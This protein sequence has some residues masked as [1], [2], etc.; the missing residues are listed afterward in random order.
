MCRCPQLN[1][2]VDKPTIHGMLIWTHLKTP[3]LKRMDVPIRYYVR[4]HKHIP[5]LTKVLVPKATMS[6]VGNPRNH[7]LA[8][9]LMV[10]PCLHVTL[11]TMLPTQWNIATRRLPA[12]KLFKL[13][14][15]QMPVWKPFLKLDLQAKPKSSSY[16]SFYTMN[17]IATRR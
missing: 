9:S 13:L 8:S 4:V 12:H 5:T 6:T 14:Q 7:H 1:P 15:C 11:H 10:I 3:V 17:T 2:M 16:F